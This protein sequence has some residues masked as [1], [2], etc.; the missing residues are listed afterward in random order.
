M[1]VSFNR[2]SYQKAGMFGSK[3]KYKLEV[4]LD[5]SDEERAKLLQKPHW[6]MQLLALEE[7]LD[8]R[9]NHDFPEGREDQEFS[10]FYRDTTAD[11]CRGMTIEN[12][13]PDRI[14]EAEAGVLRALKHWKAHNRQENSFNGETRVFEL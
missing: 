2:S 9:L 3:T 5:A 1:Q 14:A 7:P 10:V 8:K 6:F 12:D 11:L 4:I 13:N